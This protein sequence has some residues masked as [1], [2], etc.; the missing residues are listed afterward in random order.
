MQWFILSISWEN[1]GNRPM[2][3]WNKQTGWPVS[4]LGIVTAIFCHSTWTRLIQL[5]LGNHTKANRNDAVELMQGD[6]S[7]QMPTDL[8]A[9]AP[10]ELESELRPR[11]HKGIT[12]LTVDIPSSNRSPRSND[13]RPPSRWKTPEFALYYAV[14]LTVVPIMVWAPVSLS[15]SA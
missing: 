8:R 12:A 7:I 3:E 15:S 11:K 2:H 6:V 9:V 10:F 1:H 13:T 14:F 5:A 4:W